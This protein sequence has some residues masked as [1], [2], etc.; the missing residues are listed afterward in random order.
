MNQLAFRNLVGVSHT[1][2]EAKALA[3]EYEFPGDP[4]EEGNPTMRPGKLFDYFPAPYPNEEAAR[5]ANNGALPPDL[6]QI[7]LGRHG[8]EDYVFSVLLGYHDPP[9]GVGE[10]DDMYYNLYF[11]GQWIGMAQALFNDAVE[12]DD[13]EDKMRMLV[14]NVC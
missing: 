4:D 10:Q 14:Y 5:F 7:I 12:Y 2:E 9:A 3:E 13:G 11:P 6:S 8:G 1:E